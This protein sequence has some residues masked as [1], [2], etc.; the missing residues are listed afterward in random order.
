MAIYYHFYDDHE[1]DTSDAEANVKNMLL[2]NVID[3]N[4][5]SVWSLSA[6]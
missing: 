5:L 2:S 6:A 3:N 1:R 4:R